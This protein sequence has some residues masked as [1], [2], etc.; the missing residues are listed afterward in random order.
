MCGS[1]RSRGVACPLPFPASDSSPPTG[2]KGKC[3]WSICGPPRPVAA[4]GGSPSTGTAGPPQRA[5]CP[6]RVQCPVVPSSRR[7]VVAGASGGSHQ[8]RW[9]R[10]IWREHLPFTGARETGPGGDP[11]PTPRRAPPHPTLPFRGGSPPTGGKGREKRGRGGVRPRR[12]VRSPNTKIPRGESRPRTVLSGTPCAGPPRPDPRAPP[13]PRSG[14]PRQRHRAP[15]RAG[16]S[17]FTAPP[18]G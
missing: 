15:C 4:P 11:S 1:L 14:S 9:S 6:S 16:T 3:L 13:Q 12:C 7:P 17:A 10:D 8:S 2:G 5:L 18:A